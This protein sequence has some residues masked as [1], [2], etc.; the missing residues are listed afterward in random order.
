M[1]KPWR[2]APDVF[3]AL[4]RA[5][6]YFGRQTLAATPMLVSRLLGDLLPEER[7]IRKL[8]DAAIQ[9][10]A[11]QS[12]LMRFCQSEERV[13]VTHLLLSFMPESTDEH[14]AQKLL[15]V[16]NPLM[17]REDTAETWTEPLWS[18]APDPAWSGLNTPPPTLDETMPGTEQTPPSMQP[19]PAEEMVPPWMQ[20]PPHPTTEIASENAPRVVATIISAVIEEVTAKSWK[21]SV[22]GRLEVRT[23]G[24]VLY[25]H[26][27]SGHAAAVFAGA[28]TMGIGTRAVLKHADTQETPSFFLPIA[29]MESVTRQYLPGVYDLL[30][31]MQNG[32]R[33]RVNCVAMQT[34]KDEVEAA[35]EAIEN[36]IWK[37]QGVGRWEY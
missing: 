5:G 17:G 31:K 16:L 21:S 20:K 7:E 30:L 11:A 9:Q 22:S 19:K 24:V 26:K 1:I 8:W 37:R 14:T 13:S 6:M 36:L 34:K 32:R 18:D 15:A 29:E 28:I 10:N 2:P 23:D 27:L 4:R 12:I 33:F 3:D 35:A 25:K